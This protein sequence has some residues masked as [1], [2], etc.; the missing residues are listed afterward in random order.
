MR[1]LIE[2]PKLLIQNSPPKSDAITT[3]RFM[4]HRTETA[5]QTDAKQVETTEHAT[6]ASN[7]NDADPDKSHLESPWSDRIRQSAP[8]EYYGVLA[9]VRRECQNLREL[10]EQLMHANNDAHRSVGTL[11]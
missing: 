8:T 3:N 1:A 9:Q 5:I 7:K 11:F 6:Q 10:N 4:N 2:S